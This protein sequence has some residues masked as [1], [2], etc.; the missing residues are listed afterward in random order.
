MKRTTWAVAAASLLALTA[1]EALADGEP[2]AAAAA[3]PQAR[4]WSGFYIGGGAGGGIALTEIDATSGFDL[5]ARKCEEY[6]YDDISRQSSCYEP[7]D[8]YKIFSESATANVDELGGA[9]FLGTLQ[10]GYDHQINRWVVG[11]FADFDWTNIDS[12]F[13]FAFNQNLN[14]GKFGAF[15]SVNVHGDVEVNNMWTIGGRV[16]LLVKPDV[17][18]YGLAGYSQADIDWSVAFNDSIGIQIGKYTGSTSLLGGKF[19]GSE[20]LGGLTLGTGVEARLHDNW[21]LKFEY[22][23]TNLDSE[24]LFNVSESSGCFDSREAAMASYSS[25]RIEVRCAESAKADL[26]T[27]IHSVR[28]VLTYKFNRDEAPP[29]APL[30]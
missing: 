3:I 10:V 13:D 12:D 8:W 16:G 1:G 27:D 23:Y 22:R 4:T 20:T 21:G 28:V 17:L 26:D 5:S 19:S 9:G 29:P 24:T 14:L 15:Q 18:L 11:A 2:A 25:D 30:K 6:N 7:S